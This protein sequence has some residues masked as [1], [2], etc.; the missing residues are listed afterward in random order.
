MATITHPWQNGPTELIEFALQNL[1]QSDDFHQRIAF[2]LLDIGVE[3][4]FKTYLLLPDKTTKVKLPFGD[5]KKAAEG[6]FHELCDGL[7]RAAGPRLQGIDVAD[8]Q[9][10]HDLRNNLYHRGNGI[11]IPTEKAHKYAEIAVDLLNRL[12]E[13]DLTQELRKPELDAKRAEEEKARHER[14]R[15]EIEGQL[16]AVQRER[17]HLAETAAVAIETIYPAFVLPSVTRAFDLVR[18]Q[19]DETFSIKIEKGTPKNLLA[20]YLSDAANSQIQTSLADVY[21]RLLFLN[22]DNCHEPVELYLD[23]LQQIIQPDPRGVSLTQR[24]W[25]YEYRFSAD[26][27]EEPQDPEYWFG[28]L[29]VDVEYYFTKRSTLKPIDV[30]RDHRA[31]IELGQNWL[32]K[33]DKNRSEIEQWLAAGSPRPAVRT[34]EKREIQKGSEP[35]SGKNSLYQQFFADLLARIKEA[36]PGSTHANRVFP[37]NWFWF[38]AGR[39]GFYLGWS[40][41]R[42]DVL[43]IELTIASN[44]KIF[45]DRAFQGLLRQR[46]EIEKELG[47]SLIWEPRPDNVQKMVRVTHPATITDEPSELEAAK[48]WAVETMVKFID[49]FQPR[50]KA[51]D[52]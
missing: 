44:D 26:Y 11:T 15:K 3:T 43:R 7:E 42:G 5:R 25:L 49:A 30:D 18:R 6:N 22:G 1:H 10:Y 47:T 9:F 21:S 40:F 13:V 35:E 20:E 50:I 41:G 34:A 27:P 32:A 2:L 38:G 23:L 52:K 37:A 39:S 51:L 28:Y 24:T 46:T 45:N 16:Q 8:V 48:Q 29:N 19:I 12:L 36:R 33:L 17:R 14:E 31:I 4:L